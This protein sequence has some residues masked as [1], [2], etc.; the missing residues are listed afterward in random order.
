MFFCKPILIFYTL[1]KEK[2]YYRGQYTIEKRVEKKMIS[3]TICRWHCK[4]CGMYSD[5]LPNL[6]C[7]PYCNSKRIGKIS[8]PF[9]KL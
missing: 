4:S 8:Q 6:M 2:I 7:C 5:G 1:Q 3:S 9:K